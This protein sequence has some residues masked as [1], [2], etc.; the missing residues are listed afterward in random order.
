MLK[1]IYG[2]MMGEPPAGHISKGCVVSGDDPD[3]ICPKCDSED[4]GDEEG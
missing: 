2:M 3:W 1:A 4:F